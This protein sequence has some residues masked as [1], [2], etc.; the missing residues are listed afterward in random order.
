LPQWEPPEVW[1]NALYPPYASLPVK[2]LTFTRFIQQI[3]M[4][5]PSMLTGQEPEV[6]KIPPADATPAIS[7]A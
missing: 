1:L 4:A 5:D 7:S 6:R 3:V 2:V